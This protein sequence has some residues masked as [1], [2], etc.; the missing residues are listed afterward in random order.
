MADIRVDPEDP[1]TYR[2]TVTD[3]ESESIHEVHAAQDDIAELGGGAAAETV[4]AESFRFLL[5]REPQ[6]SI[7][8]VFDLPAIARFF[9]E[10]PEEMRLRL[11]GTVG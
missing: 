5:E 7:M 1:D 8:A 4:I 2:V 9:P 3:G 10:Y 11:E 6:G